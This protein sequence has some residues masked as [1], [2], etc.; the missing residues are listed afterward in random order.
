MP[1]V[2]QESENHL[3]GR[4]LKKAP[5][6]RAARSAGIYDGVLLEAI[7]RFKYNGK[8]SLAKPLT[9]IMADVFPAI[10]C[11]LIVPVPLHKTRLKERGFNQSLL[12]A[13]G[14]VRIYNRPMDYLNLERI[15]ATEHQINL[16]GKE[17]LMNVKDTFAVK[18]K[19]PFRDKRILLI[20]DVYTTGATVAE[21][22][23][24]LKKAGAKSVDVLTLARVADL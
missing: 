20:D 18:D 6:F 15:R 3:C 8:T 13:K 1:F 23:K 24:T 16:K 14:L 21:C 17:R 5:P 7:H 19:A 11:D 12:L 10:E 4:C 2:S 9:M 22:S